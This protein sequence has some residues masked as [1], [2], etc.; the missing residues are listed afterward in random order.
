MEGA[1]FTG[2]DREVA[3]LRSDEASAAAGRGRVVVIEGEAGIG[4]TRL[5]EESLQGGAGLLLR[6]VAEELEGNLPFGVIV[7]ALG[8]DLR[9][10]RIGRLLLTANSGEGPGASGDVEFRV[11]EAL[12]AHIE[13]LCA[14][15]AA[16]LIL[17]DLHWADPS[18]IALLHRL[19]RRVAQLPLL[20]VTTRRTGPGLSG[21]DRLFEGLTPGSVRR[22]VLGPLEEADVEAMAKTVLGGEP[23]PRLRAHLAGAS[24]NPLFVMELLG[25]VERGGELVGDGQ[26]NVDLAAGAR[27]I[28]LDVLVLHRLSFLPPDTLE[29]L[30]LAALFGTTFSV[31]DLCRVL[32]L[33]AVAVAPRLRPALV[34][35][36]LEDA[37]NRFRF[38]HDVIREALY[39]DVPEPLRNSLH[40]EVA[41]AL[42]E[43]G[44]PPERVA[45]HLLRGASR[46]NPD[47]VPA[48]RAIAAS[49]SGRVPALAADILARAAELSTS[50]IDREKLLA[51]QVQALWRSGRLQEAEAVCHALL[52]DRPDPS[53]RLYLAQVLVAQ[54]RLGEALAAIREGLAVVERTEAVRARLLAWAG[55]VRLYCGDP[56]GAVEESE[57]ARLMGEEAG[58]RFAA[59]VALATQACVAHLGGRLPEAIELAS[60]ALRLEAEPGG[61]GDH[62]PIHVLLAV[63][64]FDAGRLEEGRA[65]VGHALAACEARGSRWDLPGCHWVAARGC[66][67]SG[68]WDD[69][70]AELEAVATLAEELGTPPSVLDGHAISALIALHRGDV[71]AA[72]PELAAAEEEAPLLGAQHL[73][74]W[75]PWARA[76]LAEMSG[77]PDEALE[78]LAQTWDICAQIGVRSQFPVFGPDLVRLALRAGE[79]VR[80]EETAAA[81][82]ESEVQAGTPS[83]KAA[84]LRC[85][86]L[87]GNDPA[88]LVEAARWYREGGRPLEAAQAS[89]EAASALA[90]QGNADRA[91]VLFDEALQRY[92][93]LR[94]IHHTGRV[95]AR[96]RE[97]G[98]RRGHHGTRGRPRHGWE[99]LTDTELAVA[100]LVAEGLSNPQIAQRLFRSRHTV[101]THVSHILSK[102]S[103]GSRVELATQAA[104]RTE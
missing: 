104:R 3:A 57:R 91:R 38:R 87:L 35:G 33:S 13:D 54:G 25:V 52:A 62:F 21:L 64:L 56:A 63:F 22:L 102:L 11:S 43:A 69:A 50:P 34:S 73:V 72:M 88:T 90:G 83:V 82:D 80:A 85:R 8:I 65:A 76:L 6:G 53:V 12:L 18:S 49:L 39:M 84:A 23:G 9:A 74:D 51:E 96:L 44:A 68:R 60:K 36:V 32:A 103:L 71:P 101:H 42:S 17:E 1:P 5:L 28:S 19:G 78:L 93:E 20:V 75:V 89:E 86:G 14:D 27:P 94:A 41:K 16:T 77:A 59:M 40:L 15:G 81:L 48:L 98:V 10:A 47:A 79:R 66:F 29:A 100:A 70:L 37:G 97:L 7:D 26:G 61:E 46:E 4:K 99:S 2:R 67:L 24:G 30:R 95:E 31:T 55:W 92:S 58:D 45:G